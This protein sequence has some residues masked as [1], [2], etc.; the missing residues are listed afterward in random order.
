MTAVYLEKLRKVTACWLLNQA[1]M[2]RT[3][4]SK[5]EKV[6]DDIN[7]ANSYGRNALS[8]S[9]LFC[10][11]TYGYRKMRFYSELQNHLSF[12]KWLKWLS[13]LTPSHGDLCHDIS[14]WFT[15][16]LFHRTIPNPVFHE[17]IQTFKQEVTG[18]HLGTFWSWGSSEWRHFSRRKLSSV[19]YHS[20]YVWV[21][22]HIGNTLSWLF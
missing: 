19:Q 2:L 7:A 3:T 18:L 9:I 5:S 13:F 11:M 22:S 21:E 1:L 12:I 10:L 4:V 17:R 8:E 6:S 15:A 20:V 16:C 14:A